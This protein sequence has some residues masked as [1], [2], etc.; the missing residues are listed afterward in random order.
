MDEQTRI[1]LEKSDRPQNLKP[2]RP[3]KWMAH[4]G[5]YIEGRQEYHPHFRLPSS[6]QSR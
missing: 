2:D 5:H 3:R 6:G 1:D 4:S